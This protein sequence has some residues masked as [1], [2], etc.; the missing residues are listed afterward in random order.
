MST[1]SSPPIVKLIGA[2]G[3]ISLGKQYAGRQVLV[4]EHE[5]GVWLVRT[6]TVVPDNERWLHGE[7]AAADLREALHWA[8]THPASDEA[9]DSLLK[10]LRDEQ[11]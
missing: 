4:E 1:P 7:V 10:H 9:T 2:N 5:P 6:A 11:G 3:Q 8:Q